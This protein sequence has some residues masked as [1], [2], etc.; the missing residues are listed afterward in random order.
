MPQTIVH[1]L[2]SAFWIS[3]V[4]CPSTHSQPDIRSLTFPT[5]QPK[6]DNQGLTLPFRLAVFQAEVPDSLRVAATRR[7]Q[8]CRWSTASQELIGSLVYPLH[9]FTSFCVSVSL[10]GFRDFGIFDECAIALSPELPACIQSSPASSTV[11]PS[12]TREI[13]LEAIGDARDGGRCSV[14][15]SPVSL[16]ASPVSLNARLFESEWRLPL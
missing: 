13:H 12:S 11:P 4:N 5:G 15:F 10:C 16:N 1:R 7:I 3:S 2:I 14:S 8:L 6:P 9:G